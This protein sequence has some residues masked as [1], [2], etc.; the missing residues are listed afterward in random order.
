MPLILAR[1]P[2]ASAAPVPVISMIA[3]I[4]AVRSIRSSLVDGLLSARTTSGA[5]VPRSIGAALCV[6]ARQG[7][8]SGV[9]SSPRKRT[10]RTIGVEDDTS[11]RASTFDQSEGTRGHAFL[12]QPL[13]FAEYHRRY[14][15]AMLVNEFGGDQRLQQFAAAPDMQWQPVRCLEPADLLDDVTVNALGFLPFKTLE[16][17]RD[18]V[19]SRFVER[20]GDV[21]AL[22]WPVGGEDLVGPAAQEHVEF[23]G[24]RLAHGLVHAFVHEGHGPPSE[25]E[26]VA[27]ILLG[28][29]GTLHDA[30]DHDLRDGDD[31]SHRLSPDSVCSRRTPPRTPSSP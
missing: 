5:T 4:R 27:R 18:D 3:A 16:T 22:L 20:L 10:G 19:F 1:W 17:V 11:R 6:R 31:R 7:G 13:S 24:D 14:P 9:A 2:V 23:I 8:V 29:T 21:A 26:P 15:E 25:G 30:V 28:A 12:E